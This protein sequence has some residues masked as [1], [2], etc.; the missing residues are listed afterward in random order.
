MTAR[1]F[2]E[3]LRL[4]IN[5]PVPECARDT[6]NYLPGIVTLWEHNPPRAFLKLSDADQEQVWLKLMGREQ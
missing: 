5:A 1:E 6:S 2:A 3:G 4:V